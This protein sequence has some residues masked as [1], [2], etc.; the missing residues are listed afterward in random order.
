MPSCLEI[1]DTT[2]HICERE[3]K[4]QSKYRVLCLSIQWIKICAFRINPKMYS[5]RVILVS[6]VEAIKNLKLSIQLFRSSFY[7]PNVSSEQKKWTPVQYIAFVIFQLTWNEQRK[8][9]NFNVVRV[10]KECNRM[11]SQ[12]KILMT[13]SKLWNYF[14]HFVSH[15]ERINNAFF[16]FYISIRFVP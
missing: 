6:I 13:T 4:K 7:L 5:T 10:R 14:Q 3:M 2:S 11:R 8:E 16:L 12:K 15:N 9:I 1:C